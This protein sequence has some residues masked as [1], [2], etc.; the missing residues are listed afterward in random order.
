MAAMLVVLTMDITKKY[1]VNYTNMTY[2]ENKE[3]LKK[4]IIFMSRMD[5]KFCK[6]IFPSHPPLH[7]HTLL[8]KNAAP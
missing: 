1:F 5:S 2:R 3:Y 6:L 4:E 8:N 7:T